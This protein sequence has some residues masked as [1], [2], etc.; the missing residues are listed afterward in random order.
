MR[1]HYTLEFS[2]AAQEENE[3]MEKA[4]FVSVQ[5]PNET[6]EQIIE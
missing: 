2:F 4:I 6:N 1:L 3:F 5:T